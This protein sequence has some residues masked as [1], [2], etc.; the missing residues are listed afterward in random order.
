M[1]KILSLLNLYLTKKTFRSHRELGLTC[2]IIYIPPKVLGR[3]EA[4]H[5]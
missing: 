3:L 4:K 5:G 1:P 2:Q